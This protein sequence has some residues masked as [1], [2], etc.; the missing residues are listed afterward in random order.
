MNFKN[1]ETGIIQD[2]TIYED[3]EIFSKNLYDM[4]FMDKRDWDTYS[5]LFKNMT[6][7]L[8]PPDLIIY[9]KADLDVILNRISHRN[10]EYE[11]DIDPDYIKQLNILY[12]SWIEKIDWCK[13][14]VIDTNEFNIFKNKNKF[15]LI[16]EQVKE[17]LSNG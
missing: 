4:E 1:L 3:V 15:D 13:T 6:A 11:N 5:E 12:D 8:R 7:F 14:L 16:V 10:R 9:L 17:K 2:R